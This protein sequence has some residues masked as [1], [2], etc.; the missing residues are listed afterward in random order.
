M[1]SKFPSKISFIQMP[2]CEVSVKSTDTVTNNIMKGNC[3]EKRMTLSS[4][5]S[6]NIQIPLKQNI[7]I[8]WNQCF[9]YSVLTFEKLM[10]IFLYCLTQSN[11]F[12][13]Q[14]ASLTNFQNISLG[15]IINKPGSKAQDQMVVTID[16]DCHLLFLVCPFLAQRPRIKKATVSVKMHNLKFSSKDR[17]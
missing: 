12:I 8:T 17:S 16:F 4:L 14:E 5:H 11:C 13:K 3:C 9:D 6:L 1:A 2:L 10:E 15:H 7:Y